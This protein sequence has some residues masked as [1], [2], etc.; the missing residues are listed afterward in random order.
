M[1]CLLAEGLIGNSRF[2]CKRYS[3]F[4][5]C[6]HS[7]TSHAYPLRR[8]VSYNLLILFPESL[9]LVAQFMKGVAY[10]TGLEFLWRN[11]LF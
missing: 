8:A 6:S 10:L 11:I 5:L 7:P 2:P 1:S 9:Y 4:P 3:L